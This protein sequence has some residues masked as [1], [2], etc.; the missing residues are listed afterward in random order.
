MVSILKTT[1]IFLAL[2]VG[3]AAI[4]ISEDTLSFVLNEFQIN[5]P[6][7]K[8]KL[9]SKNSFIHLMKKLS[10]NGHSMGFHEKKIQHQYQAY[11]IFTQI[12]NFNWTFRS[13]APVLFVS[14][15][16]NEKDLSNVNVSIS[17]ELFFMDRNSRKVY[18][19]YQIN[20]VQ[21]TKFLGKFND[22][23]KF[24]PSENY[25][26]PIVKHRNNF[27]G[28]QLNGMITH[29]G[30]GHGWTKTENFPKDEVKMLSTFGQ[31]HID[32]TKLQN[33]PEILEAPVGV[34]I[35]RILQ[36][37]L[38]FTSQLYIQ[39]EQ[40]LGSPQLLDNGTIIIREG[41]FQNLINGSPELGSPEFI[42]T[43]LSILPIRTQFVDFMTPIYSEHVAI[44]IPNEEVGNAIDWT[45]FINPFSY[46]LWISIIIKC[47]LFTL[48]L[49]IIEW[50]HKYK[51]VS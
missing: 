6:I 41:M 7:I 2:T 35:L 47:I 45:P 4:N 24:I 34:P 31:T 18:E 15:I 49:S 16:Q 44:F 11:I 17:D 5:Q 46:S 3:I 1:I 40:T 32:I 37:H 30:Q 9:L 39:K 14:D 8:N 26:T 12:R 33:Y 29:F 22:D 21:I 38:N 20:E 42:W 43:P 10:S 28:L 13:K 25:V 23:T 27:H 51:I 48:L 50:F 36:K 19:A